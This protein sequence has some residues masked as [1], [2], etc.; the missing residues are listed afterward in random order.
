VQNPEQ[1]PLIL[2]KISDNHPII[3]TAEPVFKM[4]FIGL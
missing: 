1:P 2:E 4:R 3:V